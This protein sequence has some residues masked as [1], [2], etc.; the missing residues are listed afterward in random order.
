MGNIGNMSIS[1]FPDRTRTFTI[2]IPDS[3]FTLTTEWS[4][5]RC[6][7]EITDPRALCK[8]CLAKGKG[9][10]RFSSVG[11]GNYQVL[12]QQKVASSLAPSL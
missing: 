1:C 12:D 3:L 5:I 7:A 11:N 6:L 9:T 2:N 4:H 8:R 10:C